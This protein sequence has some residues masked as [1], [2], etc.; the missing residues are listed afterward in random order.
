MKELEFKEKELSLQLKIKELEVKSKDCH[1]T[2]GAAFDVSNYVKFVP[3]FRETEVDKY[4]LHFEKV[5]SNLKWPADHWALLLQSSLV[6]KAREVYSALSVE[7]SSQYPLVKNA[8]LKAYELVSEAYRQKFRNAEKQAN[9]T[10]VEFAQQKELPSEVRTYID[11][12]KAET[13]NQAAVLVDDY[14]LTHKTAF[15]QSSSQVQPTSSTDM[16]N[17]HPH[18]M[19]SCKGYQRYNSFS[20]GNGRAGTF[21]QGPKCHY[22]KKRGHVMAECWLLRNN[23]QGQQQ[24]TFKSDMLVTQ[25]KP[26]STYSVAQEQPVGCSR[27]V[28]EYT[29]F[30]SEGYI[31]IP[32]STA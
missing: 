28:D 4:F 10:H 21:P 6:G 19:N 30:I 9:Q 22:C 29:P 31:L 17:S 20:S 12:R 3:D 18:Q 26:P 7:E 27:N 11:E 15:R 13:L 32:G 8:I 23:S 5:A 2:V 1:E 14:T 16:S 25:A 24:Q